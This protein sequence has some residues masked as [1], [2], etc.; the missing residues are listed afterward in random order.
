[1]KFAIEKNTIYILDDDGKQHKARVK[2]VQIRQ[3]SSGRQ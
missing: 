2:K 1:M 3:P